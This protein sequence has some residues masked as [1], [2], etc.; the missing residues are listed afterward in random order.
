[1][2]HRRRDR[3][4][5]SRS[6]TSRS[7]TCKGCE[8]PPDLQ[9]GA[10][11]FGHGSRGMGAGGFEPPSAKARRFYRPVRLTVVAALP[12]NGEGGTRTHA[13]FLGADGFRDRLAR[14][15]PSSPR[16]P[17]N[18]KPTVVRDSGLEF[19]G[20]QL[21][22]DSVRRSFLSSPPAIIGIAGIPRATGQP[23]TG[24]GPTHRRDKTAGKR[25]SLNE[26]VPGVSRT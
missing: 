24:I 15:L 17:T 14:L 25:R 26:R 12:G 2:A 6:G 9:S 7:R 19:L 1:M 4:T 3:L 21:R 8:T 5:T 23:M 11:P 16:F 20:S 18:K 22:K 13:P 10:L